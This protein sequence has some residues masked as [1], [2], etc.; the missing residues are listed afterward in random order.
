MVK[1]GTQDTF[2]MDEEDVVGD[3]DL[4]L[5]M[6]GISDDPYPLIGRGKYPGEVADVE[7]K[8]S[9]SGN[10]MWAMK[11][12]ITGGENQGRT[13]FNY[14]VFTDQGLPRVKQFMQAVAPDLLAAGPL[15][16]GVIAEE[17]QLEGRACTIRLGQER[18]EGK[19][20]NSVKELTAPEAGAGDFLP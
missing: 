18:Y 16:P 13:F 1:E 3:A 9:K 8:K 5:D 14:L 20:R 10:N 4:E 11:V 7:Y 2:D 6:E 17:G 19:K 15:K 12:R